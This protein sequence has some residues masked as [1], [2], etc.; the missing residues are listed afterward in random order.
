[1]VTTTELYSAV[2]PQMS[3]NRGKPPC[4]DLRRHTTRF[5]NL[6]MSGGPQ[7]VNGN[8]QYNYSHEY[9]NRTYPHAKYYQGIGLLN[10]V[11][12]HVAGGPASASYGFSNGM[13][14]TKVKENTEHP[15][16]RIVRPGKR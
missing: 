16:K 8:S 9:R 12:P 10:E 1:V 4:R 6:S 2:E 15:L 7:I 11:K 3:S 14:M 13:L 5:G